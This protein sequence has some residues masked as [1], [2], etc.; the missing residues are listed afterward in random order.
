MKK[1]FFLITKRFFE[2]SKELCRH[3]ELMDHVTRLTLLKYQHLGFEGNIQKNLKRYP[4][5]M[6]YP[7]GKRQPNN[8]LPCQL[9]AKT[10]NGHDDDTSGTFLPELRVSLWPET[11]F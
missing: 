6:A 8:P 2:H 9:L 1:S 7:M 10:H 11:S 3:P 4:E 5:V